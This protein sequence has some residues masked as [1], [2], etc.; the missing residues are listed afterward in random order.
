MIIPLDHIPVTVAESWMNYTSK[1]ILTGVIVF[2]EIWNYLPT[3]CFMSDNG[4]CYH[5]LPLKAF[6]IQTYHGLKPII[7]WQTTGPECWHIAQGDSTE[8][9]EE[10]PEVF[11]PPQ[12][13]GTIFRNKNTILAQNCK[14]HKGL[15]WPRSNILLYLCTGPDNDIFLWPVHKIRFGVVAS[16]EPLPD[17]IKNTY[18]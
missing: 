4:E 11:E 2:L 18:G 3:F 10:R 8:I 13:H 1:K 7:P 9:L 15:V 16:T 12:S 17:W 5:D 6:Q 14:I